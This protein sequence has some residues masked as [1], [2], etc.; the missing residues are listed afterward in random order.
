VV[1]RAEAIQFA[2]SLHRANFI[3]SHPIRTEL[4]CTEP[5]HRAVG[6]VG[7]LYTIPSTR[8]NPGHTG[9]PEQVC[10]FLAY[11][12]LNPLYRTA[13]HCTALDPSRFKV[14][15]KIYNQI[16]IIMAKAR[17]KKGEDRR[18]K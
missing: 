1:F 12:L 14:L 11:M 15:A 16:F 4:N 18:P 17:P 2:H 9:N 5:S 6:Q 13:P 7:Q 8:R 10:Q 3:S